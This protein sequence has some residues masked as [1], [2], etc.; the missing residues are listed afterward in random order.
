MYGVQK[1]DYDIRKHQVIVNGSSSVS[2]RCLEVVRRSMVLGRFF[3]LLLE[4]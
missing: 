2:F 4:M 3:F 1:Y